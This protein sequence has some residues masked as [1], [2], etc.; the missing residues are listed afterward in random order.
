MMD[1]DAIHL[2]RIDS[3]ID[4]FRSICG[5]WRRARNWTTIPGL[6][7]CPACL[8]RLAESAARSST[9]SA[10]GDGAPSRRASPR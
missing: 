2:A 7:T 1:D 3:P 4:A 8:A 5:A 6:V 10:A 9:P